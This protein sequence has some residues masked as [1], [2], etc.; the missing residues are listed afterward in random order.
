M[1]RKLGVDFGYTFEYFIP[2]VLVTIIGGVSMLAN[3]IAGLIALF[4]GISMLLIKT[5]IE[6]D[7]EIKAVRKY[8]AL[9]SIHF[10]GWMFI[11]R[12]PL[13]LLKFT[14][15]SKV[16]ESR[17]STRTSHLKTYDLVF[18]DGNNNEQEL[19]DFK[20]YEQALKIATWISQNLSV[21]FKDEVKENYETAL[22]NKQSRK[23]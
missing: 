6:I 7:I 15:T 21:T 3:I 9:F 4:V 13:L 17:A 1:G 14:H 8:Y 11:P 18:S 19:N 10:G 23:R 20:T 5:G 22:K 12:F 2:G 16:M